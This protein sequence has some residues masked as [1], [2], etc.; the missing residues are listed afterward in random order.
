[1]LDCITPAFNIKLIQ[2]RLSGTGPGRYLL[3]VEYDRM[4]LIPSSRLLKMALLLKQAYV[5][6][7]YLLQLP[8]RHTHSFVYAAGRHV[9][10][11]HVEWTGKDLAYL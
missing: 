4:K 10:R 5:I 2:K 7:N 6:T 3:T 9:L 11:S 8:I 1:M